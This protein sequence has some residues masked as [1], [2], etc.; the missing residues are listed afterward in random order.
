MILLRIFM[1]FVLLD[2]AVNYGMK[3][4]G[5]DLTSNCRNLCH[6][7]VWI[8]FV[9][10]TLKEDDKAIALLAQK[11]INFLGTLG[12]HTHIR[13]ASMNEKDTDAVKKAVRYLLQK[14][15]HD[16]EEPEI[17]KQA[18]NYSLCLD[19]FLN[20]KPVKQEQRVEKRS[21]VLDNI[22]KDPGLANEGSILQIL[23]NSKEAPEEDS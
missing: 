14:S 17:M 16:T 22:D 4:L 3:L 8:C 23:E 15:F 21:P 20:P 13:T 5:E 9:G 10:G 18:L 12:L 7:L 2:P 1:A 19:M 6:Q 11:K